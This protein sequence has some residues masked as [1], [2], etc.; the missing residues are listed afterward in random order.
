MLDTMSNKT[1]KRSAD[2]IFSFINI[3]K[4]VSNVNAFQKWLKEYHK[5]ND[6]D[7]IYKGYKFFIDVCIRGFIGSVIYDTSL[8][9]EE[10]FTFFRAR[11]CGVEIDDIPNTCEKTIFIKN[12]W[13][14]TKEIRKSKNWEGLTY[15][16]KDIEELLQVF[17]VIYVQN[18]SSNK[19]LSKESA[20][21]ISTIF[22]THNLLNDTRRGIPHAYPLAPI[23]KPSTSEKYLEDVYMGYAY[24]LQYLW[25]VLLGKET[26]EGSS[27][28]NLHKAHVIYSKYAEEQMEPKAGISVLDE[29]TIKEFIKKTN[30]EE[31]M[32]AGG[33][34]CAIAEEPSDEDI[35]KSN[36]EKERLSKLKNWFA[37]DRFFE[38]IQEEIIRPIEEG[39]K[40]KSS[41]FDPLLI[42]E[43]TFSKNL[44]TAFL[45]T[46]KI[47]E[48]TYLEAQDGGLMN[49]KLD[50]FFLW[51]DVDVL[52]PLK[53]GEFNG[54][55]AFT[56]TLIGSVE[57]NRYVGR[58]EVV[59]VRR[60][61]HPVEHVQGYDYSYS[62]LIPAFG[63][64]SD[65]SGWL[66]FFDCATDYSGYGG[67]LYQE[68]EKFI[69]KF[70]EEKKIE[71][72]ELDVDIKIF[73]EYLEKK[74]V[75]HARL[76]ISEIQRKTED[77]IGDVKGIF[78]EYLFYNWLSEECCDKCKEIPKCNV[79][80]NGE[81]I[82]VITKTETDI[83]IFECKVNLH[84][85]E[86]DN[87]I[88][89]INNKVKAVQRSDERKI[90]PHLVVFSPIQDVY[91]KKFE[92]EGIQVLSP[93]FNEIIRD[94]RKLN[95]NERKKIL[96]IIKSDWNK[97]IEKCV[98]IN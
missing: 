14:S 40:I 36:E 83:R 20:L 23:L 30:L 24:A 92:E 80:E 37:L 66:I 16:I 10:D 44:F 59:L 93:P 79:S 49:K 69:K 65:Y 61:K 75:S 81:Q 18:V 46:D 86:I 87:T 45:A 29:E 64:I 58:D 55:P 19:K 88:R 76:S 11:F 62:I 54:V 89:Q 41:L 8:D 52:D 84:S 85:D 34:I 22:N 42:I 31:V 7:Q 96:K 1:T 6:D 43:D 70:L 27:L 82:D 74:S 94:W 91:K 5:I 50:H 2:Q 3:L 28:E 12:V 53:T 51:Y 25:F 68:A 9:L 77:F 73:K 32:G 57:K 90:T 17:D 4:I 47:R 78:F 38:I 33:G 67:S 71:L 35:K 13:N 97:I 26:F 95:V 48:P 21:N 63:T 15:C 56:T 39:L 72:I 98:D 60:L